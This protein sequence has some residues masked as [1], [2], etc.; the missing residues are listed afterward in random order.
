M[1]AS[2]NHNEKRIWFEYQI[3]VEKEISEYKV[4]K[5][6]RVI[7]EE[8]KFKGLEILGTVEER[9]LAEMIARDVAYM[10]LELG[11]D[12]HEVVERIADTYGMDIEDAKQF[13]NYAENILFEY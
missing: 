11:M 9:E 8:L 12:R 1:F 4:D 6:T 2:I 5:F 7:K 10:M 3:K 13:F